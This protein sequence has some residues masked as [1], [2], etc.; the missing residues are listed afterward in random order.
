MDE[1]LYNKYVTNELSLTNT[2]LF[3][4]NNC[5]FS[6]SNVRL[7]INQY[8]VIDFKKAHIPYLFISGSNDKS[9]PTKINKKKFKKYTD[10]NS[11]NNFKE[12]PNRTHNIIA[13]EN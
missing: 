7:T 11:E 3:M 4:K 13:Q 9:Q 6:S 1:N 8:V 12:F 2:Q 10:L 5:I